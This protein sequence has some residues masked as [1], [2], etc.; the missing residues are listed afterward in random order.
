M[1]DHLAVVVPA[2]Q[3]ALL[4]DALADAVYYRDRPCTAVLARHWTSYVM[5]ARPGW[6]APVLIWILAGSWAWRRPGDQR[7]TCRAGVDDVVR[8]LL[9]GARHTVR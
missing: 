7:R 1:P 8:V 4:R 6:P 5:R 3:R 9:G 2:E